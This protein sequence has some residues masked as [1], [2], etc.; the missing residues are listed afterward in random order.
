[1]RFIGSLFYSPQRRGDS[2]TAYQKAVEIS[3][4][5]LRRLREPAVTDDVSRSILATLMAHQHNIPF[6]TS[7]YETVQ[8][9]A[10]PKANGQ[11][12]PH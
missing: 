1:M 12:K 10:V 6:L 4:D 2:D 3:D 9:M 5:L 8:E 11:M 7:V